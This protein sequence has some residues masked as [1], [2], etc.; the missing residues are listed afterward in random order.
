MNLSRKYSTH[1]VLLR[2]QGSSRRLVETPQKLQTQHL[3]VAYQCL[4]L[5]KTTKKKPCSNLLI[6]RGRSSH[7]SAC[8]N[9]NQNMLFIVIADA[10]KLVLLS[11]WD[12][13]CVHSDVFF[14]G[15]IRAASAFHR[16]Q[17]FVPN[18]VARASFFD[19]RVVY[20]DVLWPKLNGYPSHASEI[21]QALG[22]LNLF[23]RHKCRQSSLFRHTLNRIAKR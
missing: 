4:W 1:F 15:W 10:G 13:C 20:A 16:S 17:Y 5:P 14:F 2:R 21:R 22:K 18:I 8:P 3:C 9:N 6:P 19:H 7:F 11:N 12:C 23:Y